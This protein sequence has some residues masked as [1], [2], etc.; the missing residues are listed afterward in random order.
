[1]K[2]VVIGI[3]MTPLETKRKTTPTTL[4]GERKLIK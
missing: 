4:V 2:L 3:M 1:M